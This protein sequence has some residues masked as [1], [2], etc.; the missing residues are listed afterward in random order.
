VFTYTSYKENYISLF[1]IGKQLLVLWELNDIYTRLHYSDGIESTQKSQAIPHTLHLYN[2]V[3]K[4]K[5]YIWNSGYR[6]NLN[7]ART[8]NIFTAWF[9]VWCLMPLSTIFLENPEQTTDLSQVTDKFYHI[10]LYRVHLNMSGIYIFVK[11]FGIFFKQ[12]S[13]LNRG[14]Y[15]VHSHVFIWESCMFNA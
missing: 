1:N 6:W 12:P 8:I 2:K 15:K 3:Y 14:S 10:M 13:E 5:E 9:G 11:M 7:K 4:C